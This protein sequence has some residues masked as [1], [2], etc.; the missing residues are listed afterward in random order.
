MW[1]SLH[2]EEE[3]GG[4]RATALAERSKDSGARLPGFE[5]W[6]YPFLAR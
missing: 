4:F 6:F 1:F 5:S 3:L 2:M